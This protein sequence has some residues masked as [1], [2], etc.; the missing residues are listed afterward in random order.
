M[1]W[2]QKEVGVESGSSGGG[3]RKWGWSQEEVG[4]ESG[5]SGVESGR[6]GGGVGMFITHTKSFT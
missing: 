2:S 3:V 6:S 1:G 5:S 4:V